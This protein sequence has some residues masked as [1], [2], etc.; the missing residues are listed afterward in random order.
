[1]QTGLDTLI[2]LMGKTGILEEQVQRASEL[3]QR[4]SKNE[5]YLKAAAIPEGEFKAK[6]LEIREKKLALDTLYA[7]IPLLTKGQTDRLVEQINGRFEAEIPQAFSAIQTKAQRCYEDLKSL[8]P[9]RFEGRMITALESVLHDEIDGLNTA[10]LTMLKEGYAAIVGSLNKKAEDA[11]RYV[12]GL[13]LECFG[14]EYPVD[15]REF[16]VSEQNDYYIRISNNQ[17]IR[18]NNSGLVHLLPVINILLHKLPY[19]VDIIRDN[20]TT[21]A[22]PQDAHPNEKYKELTHSFCDSVLDS[23]WDRKDYFFQNGPVVDY[24]FGVSIDGIVVVAYQDKTDAQFF[25]FPWK[26]I[27]GVS[28][29][30]RKIKIKTASENLYFVPVS[31]RKRKEAKRISDSYFSFIRLF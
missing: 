20:E 28:Y 10:G 9:K 13:M 17:N 18:L 5:L 22:L 14:V 12:S 1:M 2:D 16:S 31:F 15:V 6:A 27:S 19:Q 26:M 3:R 30:A 4:F 7:E 11:A 21:D 23:Y 24:F 25:Y 29:K 8:P